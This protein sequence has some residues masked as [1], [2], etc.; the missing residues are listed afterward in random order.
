MEARFSRDC[1]CSE[2]EWLRSLPEAVAPHALVLH[3]G[4]A[5]VSLD[6]GH[7]HLRWQPLPPRRIALLRL[8][9]LQVDF[10]FVGVA[11]AE[12]QA[13]LRRFDLCMQRGGG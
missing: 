2:T 3:A 5:T 10:E 1:G 9:R 13:F 7:L 12:R 11:E 8:P 4:A 6:H